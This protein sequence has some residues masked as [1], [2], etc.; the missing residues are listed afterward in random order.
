MFDKE[1]NHYAFDSFKKALAFKQQDPEN[2][3][4]NSLFELHTALGGI[5]CVDSKGNSSE[6]TNKV[7]VNFMNNIGTRRE[8]VPKNAL[9]NQKNYY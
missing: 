2:H 9:V 6:F 7:V 8:G 5:N 1:A 4:V 3:T